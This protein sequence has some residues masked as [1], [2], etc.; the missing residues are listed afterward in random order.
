MIENIDFAY[1]I[2]Y[3]TQVK[4]NKHS[5]KPK[6]NTKNK[7]INREILNE[8]QETRNKLI[9]IKIVVGD[10]ELIFTQR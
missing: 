8:K 7:K 10:T 2:Y 3:L 1:S 6:T 5:K 4:R 9:E